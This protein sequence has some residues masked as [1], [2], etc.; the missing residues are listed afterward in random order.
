MRRNKLAV[1]IHF[2]WATWDREPMILES[3]ERRLHRQIEATCRDR[4]CSVLA[5]GG[6][7]DHVHLLVAL[8]STITLADLMHDVKRS[9]SHFVGEDLA[10]GEPF[11]WQGSYAAFSVSPQDKGRV[12]RY[13]ENQKQHHAENTFWPAAEETFE[14]VDM[15]PP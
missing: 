9:S 13:I 3:F 2:V 8:P 6:M 12:I 10:P 15:A 11:K 14:Y 5:I 7:S 4:D 1:Y